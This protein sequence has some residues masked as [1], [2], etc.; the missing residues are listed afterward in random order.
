MKEK[1]K[2]GI[3]ISTILLIIFIVLKLTGNIDW[4]WWW[5][6]SPLWIPIVLSLIIILFT[7]LFK[8]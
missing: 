8:E 1:S 4:S 3:G 6:L 7:F 2:G 5:V